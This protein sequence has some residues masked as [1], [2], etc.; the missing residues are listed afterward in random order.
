M[1]ESN[2]GKQPTSYDVEN[3]VESFHWWFVVRRKLL[4]SILSSNQVP[5]NSL[6]LDIGC[7]AGSNLKVLSSAGINA[8]GLDRS[9]YALSLARKKIK[10]PLLNGD[11]NDLPVRPKSVGLIVAMDILEHLDNDMEGIHS[12]YQTLKEKGILILTVPA[13][14]SL[15]GIQDEVTFHKRRYSRHEIVNKL[16][17]EGF[18]IMKSSYF[19]FFLFF[20]ILLGRRIIR[21]LGLRLDSENKINSPF[22]NFLL[23]AIFSF[24]PYMLKYVSFPFGV[25]ILCIARKNSAP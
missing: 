11:L 15:W 18:E 10:F 21:I 14:R 23:K 19:N 8:I 22:I 16:Q 2:I 7:G 25:S 9:F 5:T 1:D 24:E 17:Q 20:P 12:F 6:T 4:A 3:N 13:F